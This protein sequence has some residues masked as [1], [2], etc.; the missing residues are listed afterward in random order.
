MATNQDGHLVDD[1]GNVV[2]DFVW[3]NLPLQPNDIRRDNGGANLDYTLDNHNIVED[4]WN[5]YPLYTPNTEG[6]QS[7]GV[8]YVSVPNVIGQL[9]ADAT[10]TLLDATLVASVQSAYTPAVSN[11]ALTTNILTVTTA[12]AHGYSVGNS[13]VIA[14]LVNGSGDKAADV[15]LN[16]TYTIASTPLTTTFTVAKTHATVNSHA[17]TAGGTAKVAAKAGRIYAQGTAA[18]NSV[19]VGATVTLTPWA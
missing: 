13:V 5:G 1:K 14:G 11:V 9:T 12:A 17:P 10:D 3:G 19:A 6:T 7:G 18:G 16:G 8:D 15:D 2:V 4:G